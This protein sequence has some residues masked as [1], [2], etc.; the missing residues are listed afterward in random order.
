MPPSSG[1][2]GREATVRQARPEDALSQKRIGTMTRR[3]ALLALLLVL[4]LGLLSRGSP[5]R[6]PTPVHSNSN[7]SASAPSA[8]TSQPAQRGTTYQQPSV[9]R[10][11]YQQQPR[12]SCEQQ[13]PPTI[14]QQQG[15]CPQGGDHVP[16]TVDRNGR[17]RCARCGR[18]MSAS[19]LSYQPPAASYQQQPSTSYQQQAPPA[20]SCRQPQTY[21]QQGNYPQGGDHVPGKVDRNGRTHCAR[22]GRFM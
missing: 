11:T 10:T 6:V 7:V 9:P 20:T 12:G 13:A 16:G 17:V 8:A 21:Q 3:I 2:I 4:T 15:N 5:P 14:A 18:Y 1:R 22:C 19:A